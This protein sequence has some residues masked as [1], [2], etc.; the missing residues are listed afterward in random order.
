MVFVAIWREGN[1]SSVEK[2][3][4]HRLCIS[5]HFAAGK[6][7]RERKRRQSH[8]SQSPLLLFKGAG[9]GAEG[10]TENV[11]SSL[12]QVNAD[13]IPDIVNALYQYVLEDK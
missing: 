8:R 13:D 9:R 2:Y 3:A 12:H 5:E 4:R 11:Q 6:I 10:A 1:Y 7:L